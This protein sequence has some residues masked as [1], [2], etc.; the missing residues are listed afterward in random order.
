MFYHITEYYILFTSSV[1][2]ASAK[3]TVGAFFI[4]APG[5]QIVHL[6]NISKD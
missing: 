6:S 3:S 1:G 2:K 5:A 4:W